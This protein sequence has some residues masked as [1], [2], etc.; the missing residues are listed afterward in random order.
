MDSVKYET[1]A[2]DFQYPDGNLLD[3]T[4]LLWK[5]FFELVEETESNPDWVI[6]TIIGNP[7]HVL[8]RPASFSEKEYADPSF[9]LEAS[10]SGIADIEDRIISQFP[11]EDQQLPRLK[12]L[13]HDLEARYRTAILESLHNPE[14]TNL[15]RRLTGDVF[16][17]Y[18]VSFTACEPREFNYLNWLGGNNIQEEFPD[19]LQ[20][21]TNQTNRRRIVPAKPTRHLE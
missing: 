4:F 16:G 5:R 7:G 11:E 9:L 2:S 20:Q 17:V 19:R 3:Q 18:T 8:L 15:Q 13:Q 14:L 10:I 1:I 6:W 12:E 21:P